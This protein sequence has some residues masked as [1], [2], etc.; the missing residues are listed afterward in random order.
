MGVQ[1]LQLKHVFCVFALVLNHKCMGWILNIHFFVLLWFHW[2]RR[3]RSIRLRISSHSHPA[4]PFNQDIVADLN[5]EWQTWIQNDQIF[6]FKDG[7]LAL[8]LLPHCP[9]PD[10]AQTKT[11]PPSSLPNRRLRHKAEPLVRGLQAHLGTFRGISSVSV[12]FGQNC[13]LWHGSHSYFRVLT[14]GQKFRESSKNG[15]FTVRLTVRKGAISP[16]GPDHKQ[17]WKF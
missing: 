4:L 13:D 11:K 5:S 2:R 1:K 17:M 14:S 15:Y 12:L 9:S 6:G 7:L 3:P 8:P 10:T 16:L